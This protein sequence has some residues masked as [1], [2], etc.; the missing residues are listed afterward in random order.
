MEGRPT[1]ALALSV[2][3]W[4]VAQRLDR[5]FLFALKNNK[6][7]GYTTECQS[8]LVSNPFVQT[9]R[10]LD[11]HLFHLVHCPTNNW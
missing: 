7:D 9:V 10:A 8:M 6:I 3:D 5:T 1:R 4:K 2:G 11:C